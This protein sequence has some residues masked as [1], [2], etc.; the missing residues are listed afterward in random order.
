MVTRFKSSIFARIF[1]TTAAVL[2]TLFGIMYLLAVPFIQNT[3]SE[4]E[5]GAGHTIL[6]NVYGMVEQT[7]LD[8]EDYRQSIVLERKALLQNIIAVV[9]A[10]VTILE[11]QVSTGKLSRAQAKS[12]LLDE[13]RHI[14]YGHND[15][16]FAADYRSVLIS[17]PDPK[18]NG[19]D[20]SGKL[21][22]RGNL[23]VP[24]MVAGA[25]SAGEGF[26]S[27]WWQRLGS[28][29]P[30]EKLSYY[31][32]IPAFDMIIGTGIYLDDVEAAVRIRRNL[33]FEELRQRL[34]TTH[35]ARTGYVLIFDGKMNMLIHPNPNIEG[36]NFSSMLNPSTQTPIGGLML[37]VADKQQGLHYLWDKP[38]DPGNYV[39]DK[40]SWVR[41]FKEFDWYIGTSVYVGELDESA[42]ILRNRVLAVFA[43]TLLLSVLLTYL[44]S[45]K[46]TGP[47][48]QLRDTA[49]KVEN[50]DLDAR[51]NLS[52]D[53]EIGV[54][55]TAFNGMV[56]RLQDNIRDLDAKVMERTDELQI[57]NRKLEALSTTDGLTGIANR[58]RFDEVLAS[59]WSRAARSGQPLALA[60]LDVD[61]FKKYN[62]H[63]GHQAGDECLRSIAR[64][65]S[66]CVCRTGD[67]VARYGGEEFAFIAPATDAVNALSMAGKVCEALQALAL[68]HEMSDSDV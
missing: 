29:Q 33:A 30:S 15:Y 57:L 66:S 31:K 4:I 6:N 2:C 47:L 9:E 40:I 19:A 64:V 36:T 17:H 67:L 54:V 13:L 51:C 53:D 52:R 61:W 34:R 49:L 16:V 41:Y 45:R 58:R 21:D 23:I 18:L 39:Y 46:L 8:L 20:Y 38:S 48:Q 14:R 44:F 26:Y 24:P 35:I 63:Y 27:Y 37:A 7:H 56:G 1:A 12:T 50:G 60:V 68:P 62:D 25:R 28:Q 43:V 32:N 5:D 42:H 55:S 22:F 59:E 10:R 3:V 11:E 65:F